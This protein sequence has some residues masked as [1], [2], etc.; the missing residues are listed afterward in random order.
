[1]VDTALL[2]CCINR[3]GII[4]MRVALKAKMTCSKDILCC[5]ASP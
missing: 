1:M 4:Q 3:K 5:N 2:L